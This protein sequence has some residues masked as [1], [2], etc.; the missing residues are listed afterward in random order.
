MER[1]YIW[2]FLYL[3]PATISFVI[4]KGEGINEMTY[5]F[6]ASC[7]PQQ[8]SQKKKIPLEQHSLGLDWRKRA[9]TLEFCSISIENIEK[10]FIAERYR[11]QVSAFTGRDPPIE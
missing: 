1:K 8:L 3:H 9:V 2:E 10:R 11:C 4:L 7:S 6:L 5:R